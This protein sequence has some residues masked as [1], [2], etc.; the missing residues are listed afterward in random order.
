MR[1]R[2]TQCWRHLPFWVGWTGNIG[3]VVSARKLD[4]AVLTML[5]IFLLI[6]NCSCPESRW[7]AAREFTSWL[8]VTG[9]ICKSTKLFSNR[10]LVSM[11]LI[12]LFVKFGKG[13][14][15]F[16]CTIRGHFIG[17]FFMV[18]G[19]NGYF[20]KYVLLHIS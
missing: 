9:I 12:E 13:N 15:H 14:T 6:W 4:C 20:P 1:C 8:P 11:T 17:M 19:S 2:P 10:M 18:D 5:W 16:L 3:M 7:C